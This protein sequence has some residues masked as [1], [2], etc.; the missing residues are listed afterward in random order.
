MQSRLQ[1]ATRCSLAKGMS[2][3]HA[4]LLDTNE[5]FALEQDL[6]A[7][8]AGLFDTPARQVAFDRTLERYRAVHKL[9][10]DQHA[11]LSRGRND[12]MREGT[13]K[14]GP[15]YQDMLIRIERT[16]LL[17]PE[18]VQQLRNQSGAAFAEFRRQFEQAFGNQGQPGIVWLDE[19]RRFAPVPG[20]CGYSQWLGRAVEGFVHE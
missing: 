16:P 9:L 20:A 7:R 18:V 4:R 13:R 5:L 8:S 11:F 17:G 12:W 2:A 1:W 19:E 14:L 3:L 10:E 6:A 15:T